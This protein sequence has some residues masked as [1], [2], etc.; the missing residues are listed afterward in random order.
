[1]DKAAGFAPGTNVHWERIGHLIRHKKLAAFLK[2]CCINQP[3]KEEACIADE[4]ACASTHG[5]ECPI[6][7]ESGSA[8]TLNFTKCC[9]HPICTACFLR[10]R[11]AV[12][13]MF[14]RYELPTDHPL[15]KTK[16]PFCAHV[17]FVVMHFEVEMMVSSFCLSGRSIAT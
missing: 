6:C 12:C 3:S 5:I 4:N 14:V 13:Q 16:C 10:V 1:M 8:E 7:F 11:P 17:P 15:R 9:F 2:D